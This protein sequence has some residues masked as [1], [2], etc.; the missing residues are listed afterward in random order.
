M[1]I[2]YNIG[3]TDSFYCKKDALTGTLIALCWF[4][5]DFF[6]EWPCFVLTFKY[7]V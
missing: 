2:K 3:W 5:N 6:L 1:K 4:Q 7:H